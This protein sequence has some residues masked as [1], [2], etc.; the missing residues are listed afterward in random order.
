MTNEERDKMILEIYHWMQQKKRQ[1]ISNP[2]DIASRAVIGAVSSAGAGNSNLRDELN[3][4]GEAQTIEIPAYYSS[5]RLIRLGGET[6][7][8]PIL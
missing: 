8:I 4:D 7:E 3:L 6:V 2:L 5:S 1:Q